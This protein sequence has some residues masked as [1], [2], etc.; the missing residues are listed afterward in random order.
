ME[1]NKDEMKQTLVLD[2]MLRGMTIRDLIIYLM[3]RIGDID[4]KLRKQ[5]D[6]KNI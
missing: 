5:D 1:L 2:G 3:V 6:K 4:Y